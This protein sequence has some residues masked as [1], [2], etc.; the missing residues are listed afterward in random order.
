MSVCWWWWIAVRERSERCYTREK[1][2]I[3]EL[4]VRES[5]GCLFG[6]GVSILRLTAVREGD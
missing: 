6:K 3:A 5:A 1:I 4:S 2:Y